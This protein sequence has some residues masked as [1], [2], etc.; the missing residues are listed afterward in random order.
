MYNLKY[1][2]IILG[3]YALE[4]LEKEFNT[5]LNGGLT[6]D[7]AVKKINKKIWQ[8]S[9]RRQKRPVSLLNFFATI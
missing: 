3:K 1:N 7:N 5:S 8:E 2:L 6:D 9:I 4:E